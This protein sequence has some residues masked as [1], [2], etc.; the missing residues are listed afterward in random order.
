[1]VV[2]LLTPF[3]SLKNTERTMALQYGGKDLLGEIRDSESKK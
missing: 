1:M 2:L 3:L